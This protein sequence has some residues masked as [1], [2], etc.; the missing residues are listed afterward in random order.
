MELCRKDS[1]GDGRT[2]GEELG[3]PHCRWTIGTQADR[4]AV[5]THPGNYV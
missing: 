3:D 2:N 5:V 1:D 4:N